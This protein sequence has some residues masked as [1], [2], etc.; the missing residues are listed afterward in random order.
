MARG[1]V[2]DTDSGCPR[3]Q[4]PKAPRGGSLALLDTMDSGRLSPGACAPP[5]SP[6]GACGQGGKR[7]SLAQGG[8]APVQAEGGPAVPLACRINA[9]DPS[10]FLDQNLNLLEHFFL[11]FHPHCWNYDKTRK[12]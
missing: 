4:G 2:G 11:T 5:Q 7:G 1:A 8:G 6:A 10:L 9:K 3:A 12:M